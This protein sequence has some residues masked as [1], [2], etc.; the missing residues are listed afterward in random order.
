MKVKII[1]QSWWD[2]IKDEGFVS[3][4]G[5]LL[6]MIL[7]YGLFFVLILEKEG[8]GLN[9]IF[10]KFPILEMARSV[11]PIGLYVFWLLSIWIGFKFG[12]QAGMTRGAARERNRI[13][14]P[15]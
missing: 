9:W 14:I 5:K 11:S 12:K 6:F 15:F 13:G 3:I 1:S 2:Q 10:V 8:G 7:I 4:F